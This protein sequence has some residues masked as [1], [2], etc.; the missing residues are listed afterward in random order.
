MS[1]GYFDTEEAAAKAYDRA[2]IGLLG[3]AICKSI[4]NY[5]IEEYDIDE[6]RRTAPLF[7]S[8]LFCYTYV[9]CVGLIPA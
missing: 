3:E 9:L 2:A 7:H 6:V 8:V 1:V 5:P 4:L